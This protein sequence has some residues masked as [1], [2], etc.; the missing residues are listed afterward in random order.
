MTNSRDQRTKKTTEPPSTS[1]ASSIH[2]PF[3]PQQYGKHTK[4]CLNLGEGGHPFG[5]K[6]GLALSHIILFSAECN[7]KRFVPIPVRKFHNKIIARNARIFRQ[8]KDRNDRID[9]GIAQNS[10]HPFV[11]T[12]LNSVSRC[13]RPDV[14]RVSHEDERR[15][16]VL[17]L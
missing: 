12:K 13:S 2:H 4:R 16:D 7:K 10:L 14:H 15:A 6:I 8:H 3:A 11:V 5:F 17:K 9:I 1:W